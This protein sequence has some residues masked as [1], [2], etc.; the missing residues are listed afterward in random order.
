M[1]EQVVSIALEVPT[2][3]DA[4]SLKSIMAEKTPESWLIAADLCE[5]QGMPNQSKRLRSAGVLMGFVSPLLDA[6]KPHS[7]VM[8]GEATLNGIA[9][10]YNLWGGRKIICFDLLRWV[11]WIDHDDSQPTGTWVYECGVQLTRHYWL[12]RPDYRMK[13][14]RDIAAQCGYETSLF[15]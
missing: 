10:R 9:Y 12:T 2:R 7:G 11:E 3:E 14:L 8:T 6:Q 13:R 1:A 4:R 15:R 5:D